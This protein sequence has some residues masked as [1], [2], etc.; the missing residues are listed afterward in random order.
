MWKERED[1]FK[2][3]K[4]RLYVVLSIKGVSY[5]KLVTISY[6]VI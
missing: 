5:D 2:C 4:D 1:I 6:L 3:K